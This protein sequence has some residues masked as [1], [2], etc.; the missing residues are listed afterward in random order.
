MHDLRAIVR[1]RARD[2]RQRHLE[3]SRQRLLASFEKRCRTLMIG[4]LSRSEASF[5]ALWGHGKPKASL[6]EAELRWRALWE[7]FRSELLDFGNGQIRQGRAS[8][9]DYEVDFRP[10]LTVLPVLEEG[11]HG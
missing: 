8:A 1:E 11:N 4:A 3:R 9:L 10:T 7:S 5:G 2:D 6:T